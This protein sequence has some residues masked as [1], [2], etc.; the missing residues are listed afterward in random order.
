[1]A[2]KFR[3]ISN[4]YSPTFMGKLKFYGRI[5]LDFQ[6]STILKAIKR[7]IPFY[8]GKVLDVG[9]GESP[10]R[11]LLN[12]SQTAY[13]GID[14]ADADKFDYHNS[15]TIP[16]NG[17]DIPFED[18]SFDAIICTEVLEHVYAHQQLVNEIYRVMKKGAKGIVTVPW[19]ARF[20]YS[21]WDYFRYTPS[22]LSN[23]FSQFSSVKITPRGTDIAVIGNKVIILFFRNLIPVVA[24]RWVLVPFWIFLS[25][26]LILV[27]LFSHIG[28][29]LGYIDD[30]LGYTI[31]IE[32]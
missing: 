12:T 20:H 18:S 10:Y 28:F 16:F 31:L 25:P 22:S 5:I 14:I 27:V 9:C 17:T 32:K 3:P 15:D 6:F 7:E 4:T 26:I 30:P 21:P 19:S 1:M 24:W 8:K 29:N 23:I 11:F 2:E 13:Y